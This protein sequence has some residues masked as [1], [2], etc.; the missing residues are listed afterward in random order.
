MTDRPP[1]RLPRNVLPEH[2]SLVL[3]P[4]FGR[5]GFDGEAAIEVQVNET[6]GEVVLNA[7]ELEISEV[8]LVRDGGTNV[9]ATVSYLPEEEQASIARRAPRSRELDVAPSF[10]GQA[11]R[12]TAGLL[13][14]QVPG[15]RRD[16][17]WIAVTQFEATDARRASRAGTN[18][19]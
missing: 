1:Y 3:S 11:Q 5:A 12:P 9:P 2:Y 4:D 13:P 8:H 7:A 15:G 14:Q 17:F 6:T 19:T 10:F 18:R 16:E